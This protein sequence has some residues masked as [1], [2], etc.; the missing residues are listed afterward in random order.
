MKNSCR[1]ITFV[2]VGLGVELSAL[3]QVNLNPPGPPAPMFKTL[4]QVQPRIPIGANTTPGDSACLFK[5]TQ[6]GSYYLTTNITGEASKS[7]IQIWSS[8]VTLD[9]MGF[10]IGGVSG[11][12]NGISVPV[13]SVTNITI[14]NGSIYNWGITGISALAARNSLFQDL[15]LAANREGLIGG[16]KSTILNCNA[17]SNSFDGISAGNCN[18]EGSLVTGC[19]ASSNGR[20]GISIDRGV[21]RGCFSVGNTGEGIHVE[22]GSA[23]LVTDNHC[24][25]NGSGIGITGSQTICGGPGGGKCR[26][27][28]NNVV[29]NHYGISVQ[30]EGNLITRNSASGND[31]NYFISANNK[32]GVIVS[33]PN[34]GAISGDTGGAGVGTTD[35]WANISY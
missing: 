32:V 2:L 28:N 24:L 17:S 21:V 34:S 22:P 19:T 9:L 33:A 27:D 10:E 12:F 23:S 26:I 20:D 31:T 25:N 1:I 7:G 3:A 29:N 18:S 30:H 4:D 15:R 14:R 11:S 6:P 13:G 8:G 35:P 5:I 16:S